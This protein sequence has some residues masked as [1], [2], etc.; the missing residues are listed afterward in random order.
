[1]QPYQSDLASQSPPPGS[2]SA[3]GLTCLLL[4]ALDEFSRENSQA[5]STPPFLD[6]SVDT[7]LDYIGTSQHGCRIVGWVVR[8]GKAFPVHCGRWDCAYCCRQKGRKIWKKIKSSPA[9][10]FSRLLTLP[11]YVGPGR[12]WEEAI[13]TSGSVLNRFFTSLRRVI[14]LLRYVWVREVGRKSLMVHFHVL[15]DRYLP[16]SLLSRLWM[17][18]GGGYIVDIGMIR[19]S[20]SYVCKYLAKFPGY[21]ASVNQA[22]SG[23]RRYSYSRGLL[24]STRCTRSSEWSGASFQVVAPWLRFHARLLCVID[25]VFY[26]KEEAYEFL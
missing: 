22:L 24:C 16:K 21:P 15:V 20:A 14:P 17:R 18:A 12:T 11:F 26:F 1:M 2:Q 6:P 8:G 5:N 4:Q 25:G 19:S 7:R 13:A 10:S 3:E 9:G 23:K